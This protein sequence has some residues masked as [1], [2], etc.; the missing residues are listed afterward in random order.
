MNTPAYG[1]RACDHD[2]LRSSLDNFASLTTRHCM[3]SD[4][5]GGWLLLGNCKDC[6]TT[7]AVP[8]ALA[9]GHALKGEIEAGEVDPWTL[10]TPDE[11]ARRLIK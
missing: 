6:N 9:R 8:I 4:G 3:Q 7:L 2:R 5:D 1:T 10:E 11:L